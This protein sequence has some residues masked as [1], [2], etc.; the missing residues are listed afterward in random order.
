MALS[1]FEE[2]V[3]ELANYVSE[4]DLKNSSNEFLKDLHESVMYE[5]LKPYF[6]KV[7]AK[8]LTMKEVL[9]TF[10]LSPKTY[11][12]YHEVYKDSQANQ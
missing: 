12:K 5:V 3:T 10:K 11:N 4:K 2:L 7:E 1:T 6:D 9:K 8:E